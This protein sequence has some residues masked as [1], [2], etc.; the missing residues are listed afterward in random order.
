MNIMVKCSL[1]NYFL[2]I[3]FLGNIAPIVHLS[4]CRVSEIVLLENLHPLNT[5]I[6]YSKFISV[7]FQ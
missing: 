1:Y 3:D 2:P 6:L 7:E 4:H 5:D